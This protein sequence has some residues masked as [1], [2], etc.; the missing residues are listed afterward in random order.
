MYGIIHAIEIFVYVLCNRCNIV[1][2]D[3]CE[4]LI[5]YVLAHNMH[6]V[7]VEKN[8]T[9]VKTLC[10]LSRSDIQISKDITN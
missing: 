8:T 9:T 6:K 7:H 4:C 3:I 5:M 1:V 2:L 10:R